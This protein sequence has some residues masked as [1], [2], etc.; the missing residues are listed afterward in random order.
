MVVALFLNFPQEDA[1]ALVLYQSFSY[2]GKYYNTLIH[3]F[4]Q[5]VDVVAH[6]CA[7]LICLPLHIK[8]LQGSFQGSKERPLLGLKLLPEQSFS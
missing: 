2:L 4:Q 7:S 5:F 8:L 6:K 1:N 3:Y